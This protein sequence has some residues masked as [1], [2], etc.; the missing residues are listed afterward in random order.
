MRALNLL[1]DSDGSVGI[2]EKNQGY[3]IF[4]RQRVDHKPKRFVVTGGLDC[5]GCNSEH[6]YIFETEEEAVVFA[7][8]CN[9]GS[10]G[11][12]FHP[13]CYDDAN[14][15]F[16]NSRFKRNYNSFDEFLYQ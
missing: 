9:S 12:L 10:D 14:S 2:I 13:C 8:D 4:G 3:S 7:D 11:I 6:I 15:Y 1:N 5:D 16:E